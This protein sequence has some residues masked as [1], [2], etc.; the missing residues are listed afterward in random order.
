M[1]TVAFSLHLPFEF[2]RN[3]AGQLW[4]DGKQLPKLLGSMFSTVYLLLVIL[5]F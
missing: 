5:I 3:L 4:C 1:W 2:F